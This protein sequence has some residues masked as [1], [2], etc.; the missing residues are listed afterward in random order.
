VLA[1]A[2]ALFD[3]GRRPAVVADACATGGDHDAALRVARRSLGDEGVT[4][5]GAVG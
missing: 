1:T 4:T 2:F 5:V 3:R